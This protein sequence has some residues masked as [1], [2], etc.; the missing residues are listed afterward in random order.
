VGRC[1]HRAE[2]GHRDAALPQAPFNWVT[3]SP[4]GCCLDMR[5]TVAAF[6]MSMAVSDP[7]TAA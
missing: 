6:P 5:C 7:L 3:T 4:S 1:H 2:P